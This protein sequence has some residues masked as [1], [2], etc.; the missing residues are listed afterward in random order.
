MG[1]TLAAENPKWKS[2]QVE[3]Q[4]SVQAKK[5]V[6][7]S[8]EA[9][10]LQKRVAMMAEHEVQKSIKRAMEKYQIP[11]YIFRGVNTYD[12]V[13]RLLESFGIKMSKLKA[14]KSGEESKTLECEHDIATVAL[15]PCELLVSFTQVKTNEADTPWDPKPEDQK[16]D[17]KL[18]KD[19][20]DQLERDVLRFL[21]L[22][23]DIPMSSVR[24]ATNMAFPM[25]SE[26]SE[27][28]L[29]KED[30]LSE[31]APQLLGKLGVPE[32]YLQLPEKSLENPTSEMEDAYNKSICR[33]I[34]ANSKVLTK[35]S[36]D[37]GVKGLELSVR[38]IEGGFEAQS[39]NPKILEEQQVENI[40][41]AVARDARM[42]EIKQAV[43]VPKF[44]KKFQ[45]QNVNIPLKDLKNDRERFLKQTSTKSFPLFG[46]SV[47]KDVLRAT[48]EEAAHQGT[49]A[50]IDL[51]NKE[52]YVFFDEN[53]IPLD[54]KTTVDEHVQ[55]CTE[56]SD[57]QQI[58]DKLPDASGHFLQIPKEMEDEQQCPNRPE[59]NT[60]A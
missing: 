57:V 22:T 7:G 33:Y 13:G 43:L 54:Q 5:E 39:S 60:C 15:L 29:T 32:K 4:A 8:S 20:V 6:K 58:R 53:G 2:E 21:E 42:K 30:F 34:G 45:Q 1:K 51:L 10:A 46:S 16:V 49:E 37:H 18:F 27:R 44:G 9:K 12:D 48:D 24:I 35:I 56:C 14:F 19:G 40:R 25:A 11:V 3:K 26:P 47:I 31:N 55:G 23:P 59:C 38:G 41:K 50:I 28:A 52:K 36:M 17:G